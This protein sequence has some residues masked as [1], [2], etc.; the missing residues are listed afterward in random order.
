M[1]T[2]E[3]QHAANSL[4][5]RRAYIHLQQGRP[6]DTIAIARKVVEDAEPLGPSVALARAYSALEGGY[7]FIGEP[8]NAVYEEKALE[9]FRTWVL[10]DRPP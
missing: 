10:P 8:E 2:V 1:P 5:A 4:L 3:A 7:L 6:R 9:M